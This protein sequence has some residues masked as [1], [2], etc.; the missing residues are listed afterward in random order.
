MQSPFAAR[1]KTN[2]AWP[3]ETEVEHIQQIISA[4]SEE[5]S[6]FDEEIARFQ[7]II[8][9]LTRKQDELK[10]YIQDHRALTSRVHWMP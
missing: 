6:R 10:R 7:A 9:D 4:P 5:L 2:Y 3:L 8:D 1:L